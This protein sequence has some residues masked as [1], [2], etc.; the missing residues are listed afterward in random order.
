MENA[1]E[2]EIIVPL[3]IIEK[4]LI[5]QTVDS[6]GEVKALPITINLNREEAITE[7][8]RENLLPVGW[9]TKSTFIKMYS[10]AIPKFKVKS[11]AF[12]YLLSSTFIRPEYCTLGDYGED[13][14]WR[15]FTKADLQKALNLNYKTFSRF[16]SEMI[17]LNVFSEYGRKDKVAIYFNPLY[18]FKGRHLHIN[19]CLAFDHDSKFIKALTGDAKEAY[20][21]MKSEILLQDPS[22]EV[23]IE[24]E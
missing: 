16:Y 20:S 4:T 9:R 21:K 12:E 5:I 6:Y 7:H 11:M 13:K 17:R 1:I 22:N 23:F 19:V 8:R 3:K 18:A 10:S 24:L 14:K 2:A 15:D